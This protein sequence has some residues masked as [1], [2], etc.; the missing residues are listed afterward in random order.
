[1]N[2]E[3]AVTLS[4]ALDRLRYHEVRAILVALGLGRRASENQKAAW[5]AAIAA[6]WLDPAQQPH[7]L[8]R[9]SPAAQAALWR[10]LQGGELPTSLFL[11]E[12][13]PLRLPADSP[14]RPTRPQDAGAPPPSPDEWAALVAWPETAPTLP[15]WRQ[16]Q[17]VSEEL[18]YRGLL[19]P[20]TDQPLPDAP[21][22]V[23]PWAL[24]Q[25]LERLLAARLGLLPLH[26]LPPEPLP[27]QPP[28]L[29]HDLA[30]WL[31]YRQQQRDLVLLQGRWLPPRHLRAFQARLLQPAPH[32]TQSA[33]PASH[34]QAH[35]PAFLSFLAAAAELTT[36]QGISAAGWQW[37]A[38][39]PAQQLRLLWRA[40]CDA[41][42]SLRS[43]YHQPAAWLPAPWPQLLFPYL[44]ETFAPAWLTDVVLAMES[45]WRPYFVA[46]LPSLRAL[47]EAMA[48]VLAVLLHHFDAIA[49]AHAIDDRQWPPLPGG[50]GLAEAT[51]LAG[52]LP[53]SG[54]LAPYDQWPYVQIGYQLT[55]LGRWLLALP[56]ARS[57]QTRWRRRPKPA[58]LTVTPDHWL[59]TLPVDAAPLAQAHLAPFAQ[60]ETGDDPTGTVAATGVHTYRLQ[61]TT[62][63]Q[64]AAAHLGLPTLLD[65]LTTLG[66]TLTPDQ[67]AHLHNWYA[68]GQQLQLLLLPLVRTTDAALMAR[69][70]QNRRLQ[71][72]L[73]EVLSPTTA[74]WHGD[75]AAFVAALRQQGFYPDAAA[76]SQEGTPPAGETGATGEGAAPAL[77]R[78]AGALWLAAR[79]YQWLG[80]FLPLP[81]A[82]PDD[83]VRLLTQSLSPGQ[84]AAV[85]AHLAQLEDR[86]RQ[87]LDHLPFTPPPT[88]TDPEQ[89]RPL[90]AAA[91]AAKTPLQMRYFSAGRNLTTD[92]LIDPYWIE[93]AHG[94]P[95][96]RAYCHSAGAV[97]TF[98]LDR[99][100]ALALSPASSSPNADVA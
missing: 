40:W 60:V 19:L 71:P 57:P 54:P 96:L 45:D 100:E 69:L 24:R 33:R 97:L 75:G 38:A 47:D 56:G 61:A 35:W 58:R 17:S 88:P 51:R 65:A 79:I 10:L 99:I 81:V 94:I 67:L 66:L 74:I 63:G 1:M 42:P 64:A 68:A 50:L 90:V 43:A 21:W 53:D 15:P 46:H 8:D 27:A 49:P 41:P 30:Q 83:Q 28:V 87:L 34:K 39:D 48:G 44:E 92:R 26:R 3:T 31:I 70:Q 78:D 13:G 91:I 80:Q 52:A 55:T 12:Y 14:A 2:H 29:L 93:E 86:L 77:V 85:T 36:P 82:L 89:W 37:L 6:A 72:W 4:A 98:R 73:G 76:W 59:L 84:Q 16:P 20:G 22:L 5:I 32:S 7:L 95:Y 23:L 11:A 9:L 62:V 18:F 25:P